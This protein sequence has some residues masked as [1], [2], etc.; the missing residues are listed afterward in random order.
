MGPIGNINRVERFFVLLT[1]ISVTI[2]SAKR[3][4]K[5]FK[6]L[7][8]INLFPA[9]LITSSGINRIRERTS[10]FRFFIISLLTYL[11]YSLQI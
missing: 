1:L 5:S 7:Q 8:T 9:F 6:L 10:S 2:S 11:T 3:C 4:C